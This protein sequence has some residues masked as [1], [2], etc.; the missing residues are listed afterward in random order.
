MN[1]ARPRKT[2]KISRYACAYIYY[3]FLLLFHMECW[4]NLVFVIRGP[5][6]FLW[7]IGFRP[8][9]LSVTRDLRNRSNDHSEILGDV[10]GQKYKNGSTAAFFKNILVYSKTAHLLQKNTY[11]EVFGIL[12]INRSKYF[13]KILLKC[14]RKWSWHFVK[15]L[16]KSIKWFTH[17]MPEDMA[18]LAKKPIP[19][20]L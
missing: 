10:R 17:K 2:S 18:F 9:C 1:N 12:R 19:L 13:A 3:I 4:L 11:F 15:I 14:G 7:R 16:E 20:P 5:L 8:V 6:Q